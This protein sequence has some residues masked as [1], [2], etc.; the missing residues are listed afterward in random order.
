M[1]LLENLGIN[2]K[3]LLAQVVNFFILFWILKKFAYK[4]VLNLLEERSKKIEKGLK[5]AEAARKK[6]EETEI[7][8]KKILSDARKHS[9]EIIKEAEIR[10]ETSKREIAEETKHKVDKMISDAKKK[11]EEEKD[12]MVVEVKNEVADL[13]S[14]ATEKVLEKKADSEDDKKIIKKV[15]EN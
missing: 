10:A 13:V 15:I 12:K 7:E 2:G 9:R 3:I 5:D 4:P 6:L 14:L 8:S 11:I 1:E